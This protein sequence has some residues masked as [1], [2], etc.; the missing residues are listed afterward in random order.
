MSY[1]KAG[2][3]LALSGFE[4]EEIGE[5]IAE[6]IDI[7]D[8]KMDQSVVE[9]DFDVQAALDEI[10]EPETRRGDVWQLG[11][12]ILMCGDATNAE[13]V[14]R[15]MAGVKADLVVTDPPYNVAVESESASL[16]ADGRSCIMNDDMS[17][18][19][20]SNFLHAVFQRYAVVMEETAAIYVFHPSRYQRLFESTMIEEGLQV[21]I[22]C[23]WLK[24]IATFGWAQY[25]QKHEPVFYAHLNGKAPAWYGDRKQTTAWRAGLPVKEPFPE[26]VW[27]VS[28]GDVTKYVHPTQKPLEL[29]AIPIQNSSRRGDTIADF[30]GGSG[31]T[32]MTCEQLDRSCRTMELDPVFC[33]VIKK[34]YEIKTGATPI[35]IR[36]I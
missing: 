14:S 5:L 35:L 23:I 28:K 32:M 2:A 24:N 17:E 10:K 20:F 30:F 29:L 18:E 12:H 1:R 34:R 19:E 33:D 26:T 9:D 36:R 7:P 31:S 25:K 27:E 11:R 4:P 22:V 6:F 15:L 21:R 8:I 13:D 16:V 3:D